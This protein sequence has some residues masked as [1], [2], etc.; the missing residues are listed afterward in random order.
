MFGEEPNGFCDWLQNEGVLI[1]QGEWLVPRREVFEIKIE[2]APGG[3]AFVQTFVTP[4][5]MTYIAGLPKKR[6]LK[7]DREAAAR[8]QGELGI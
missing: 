5:G 1:K 4:R 2:E 8:T 7:R 6:D 3:I